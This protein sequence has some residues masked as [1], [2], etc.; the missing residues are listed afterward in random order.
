MT[1]SAAS[2]PVSEIPV[3]TKRSGIGS[4]LW[5][6]LVVYPVTRSIFFTVVTIVAALVAAGVLVLGG[7]IIAL[8]GGVFLLAVLAVLVVAVVLAPAPILLSPTQWGN[9]TAKLSGKKGAE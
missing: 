5:R 1:A 4:L 3:S 8:V 7:A 9:V 6:W 2:I